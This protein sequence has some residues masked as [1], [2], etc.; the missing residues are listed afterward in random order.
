LPDAGNNRLGGRARFRAGDNAELS[1]R[2]KL[3][4][5]QDWHLCQ[6]FFLEFFSDAI[7]TGNVLRNR[8]IFKKKLSHA[9]VQSGHAS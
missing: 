4:H 6:T 8:I 2:K 9:G 1:A 3:H 7:E 5:K